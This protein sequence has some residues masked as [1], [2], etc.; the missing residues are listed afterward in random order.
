MVNEG[1]NYYTK[2]FEFEGEFRAYWIERDSRIIEIETNTQTTVVLD[3]T[4]YDL[5]QSGL[6]IKE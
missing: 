1:Q 2:Q 3:K 6:V 5:I 4:I